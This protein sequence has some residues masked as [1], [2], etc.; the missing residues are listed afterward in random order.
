[1]QV[2]VTPRLLLHDPH[3]TAVRPGWLLLAVVG[4]SCKGCSFHMLHHPS[5]SQMKAAFGIQMMLL[6]HVNIDAEQS[7][8]LCPCELA[9]SCGAGMQ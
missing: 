4:C 8:S 9:T 1:M 2:N 7:Q 5:Y 3:P 6:E